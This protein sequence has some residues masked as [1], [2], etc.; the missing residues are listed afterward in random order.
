[1]KTIFYNQNK[2]HISAK[3]IPGFNL[4]FIQPDEFQLKTILTMFLSNAE[5]ECLLVGNKKTILNGIR[6]RFI[7]IK[8]AGG[9]VLN[10]NKHI[11][12]IKRLGFWDLPKGKMENGETKKLCAIREVEEECGIH[13][14]RIIQKLSASYH[15]YRLNKSWAIK[16]SYWYLMEYLGN[17]ILVPQKEEHIEMAIWMNPATYD[18]QKY[19]TYP[20]IEKVLHQSLFLLE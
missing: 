9:V 15:V 14:L 13:G 10:A 7:H 18:P 19:E 3:E 1:L 20:A 5:F 11:L 16:T 8:A 2:I 17:E 12:F 6:C 4:T